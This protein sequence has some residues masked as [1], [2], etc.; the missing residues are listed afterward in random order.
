MKKLF[1]IILLLFSIGFSQEIIYHTETYDNGSIKKITHHRKT[2]ER[3]EPIKSIEYD[4][5][6]LKIT[7]SNYKD[8]RY[9]G[10]Y[11]EYHNIQKNKKHMR[12]EQGYYKTGKKDGLW[13][14]WYA[15]ELKEQEGTFI[16]GEKD[17]LFSEWYD[18]GNLKIEEM[19]KKDISQFRTT[20][21]ETGE[22][23]EESSFDKGIITFS[24]FYYKNGEIKKSLKYK[25]GEIIS[26][27]YWNEDGSRQE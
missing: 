17:G 3:I 25:D 22:I 8:F 6:G 21:Y 18:N 7:E 15:N 11:V 9:H 10:L 16:N 13:N 14:R 19:F 5:Y 24:T 20:W 1:P 26:K 23:K 4:K 2:K 12:K 27:E